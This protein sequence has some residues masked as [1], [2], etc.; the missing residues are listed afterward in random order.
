MAQNRRQQRAASK[1][2]RRMANVDHDLSDT[3][4][5]NLKIAWDGCAYC[6]EQN[7]PLQRDCVKPISRGGRY[8]FDNVVPA[9]GSC[10][11]SKCNHE[12]TSWMRRKRLDEQNFLRRFI[13]NNR[14]VPSLGPRGNSV[15]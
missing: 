3:Q 9:C 7:K 15:R 10:N 6:G 5:S 4:W 14:E 1:R 8:T 11:A 12:V 13:T 2:K